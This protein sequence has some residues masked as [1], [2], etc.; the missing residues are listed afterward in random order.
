VAE[1]P[2]QLWQRA[3]GALRTP[4]VE[5]FHVWFMARPERMPQLST[6]FAALWEDVLPPLLEAVWRANPDAVAVAMRA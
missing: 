3:H 5:D 1:S 6:S 4:P 2:E